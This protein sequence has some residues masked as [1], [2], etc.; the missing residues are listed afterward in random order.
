MLTLTVSVQPVCVHTLKIP[1]TDSYN[2]VW[3]H[4]NT[5]NTDRNENA[6]LAAAVPYPGKVT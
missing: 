2:I 6:V 1:N 3:R 5:A 4:T